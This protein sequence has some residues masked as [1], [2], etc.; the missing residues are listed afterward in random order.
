VTTVVGGVYLEGC[1][2]PFWDDVYGSGGRAAA[3]IS[4]AVPDVR[5]VTYRATPLLDGVA[6]L[7]NVYGFETEGPEVPVGVSFDYVHSL[8]TPRIAPR[9]DAIQVHD[10]IVVEDDVVLRFGMLE[11]TA[12][13]VADVAI[14]D[15]QS[16][17][18]PRPFAENGSTAKRLALILNRLEARCLISETDPEAIVRELIKT[19]GA[20]VVVLK[21][22]G[23]G[24][25][26]GTTAGCS[27]VPAYRSPTVWKIG[28]GDV[29]SAAFTQFWA[30]EGRE[31]ADAADLAS[32]AT[33]HYCGTRTLPIPAADKLKELE[34][35]AVAPGHGRIYIAA[36]FFNLSERWMVEE[37]RTQLGHMGVDVFSPLHDVGPGPGEMVAPL[38]LAGVDACQAM[39]AI[40][41]G[42]DPGTVFEVGYARA[43]NIPV[44]ALAQNMRPEDLKMVIG[45][46]CQV[47]GDL[48]SAVYHAVWALP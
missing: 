1:I 26:V 43:K 9:P 27:R 44:V 39:I 4:A 33:S 12:R 48:V 46:G 28:S 31:A 5:L 36:P 14:Y 16:A 2:E 11:G 37:I 29:Y 19:Q 22:G 45:S 24:A 32:R 25:L 47:V 18:N 21:M 41:N 3:A 30:I 23:Y 34:L 7:N 35:E 40:L 38:D 17:F 42:T 6:N 8:A 15:P 10:P 20:E 13:V